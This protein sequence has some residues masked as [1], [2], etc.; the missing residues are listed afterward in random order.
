MHTTDARRR[1]LFLRIHFWAALI[2]TPFALVAALTGIVYIFTP[3]IE[4]A[5]YGHLDHVAA[6]GP[7]R[8][9]DEVVA[10][11]N[12]AAPAG[13]RLQSVQPPAASNDS[14]KLL[15]APAEAVSEHAGH[16]GMA[17]PKRPRFGP[18]GDGVVVHVDPYSLSVLGTL[19][20]KD[21]F[22]AWAKRLHSRLLQGSGWRWMIELA[23]SWLMVMLVTGV[24][25]WWPRAGQRGLPQAGARGRKAWRQWHSFLG[26][27]LG[28]ISAVILTTGLT[29][30]EQ[31]GKQIRVLR[32]LS[33]QGPAPA[34]GHLMSAPAQGVP[35]LGWQGA[36]DAARREAP[37]VAMQLT[38]PTM[39]HGVWRA[40]AIDRS[41]PLRRFD[42]ALDAFSGARLYYAGWDGDTA[43]GKATNVGIPFHRGEFGW[44]NQALLLVFGLGIVF[45]IV[46]GWVMFFKRRKRGVAWLPPLLPGAW[47]AA[48]PVAWLTALG[49]CAL[50]PL[51]AASAALPVV[52]ELVLARGG[53]RMPS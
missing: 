23:A 52:V 45:S 50:M 39:P 53:R 49:M 17:A 10:A 19:A 31:A 3:Q 32:D 20:V 25:L 11:A 38:A 42:L 27:A 44:W 29:W 41:L 24:A 30:S 14:V 9:L 43:F 18:P 2:A 22:N 28:L 6:R 15:Y 5:L 21:R 13:M 33:G 4:A 36:W 12:A 46:S 16:A 1:S 47:R 26:V 7:M 40:T 35:A 48:S 8:A 37:A 34:P 51:L